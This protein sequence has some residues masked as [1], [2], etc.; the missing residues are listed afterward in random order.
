MCIIPVVGD[1]KVDGSLVVP[2]PK[3]NIW[4][5][6]NSN[7]YW[8]MTKCATYLWLVMV[9]WMVHWLFQELK[10]IV[11]KRTTAINTE[12]NRYF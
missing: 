12:A 10:R 6:N 7:Q 9:K 1:G 8:N 3:R 4:K 2:E 11:G 5:Q